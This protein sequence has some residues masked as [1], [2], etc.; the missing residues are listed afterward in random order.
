MGGRTVRVARDSVKVAIDLPALKLNVVANDPAVVLPEVRRIVEAFT[1]AGD[2]TLEDI[3][4]F[5]FRSRLSEEFFHHQGLLERLKSALVLDE[6]V[7]VAKQVI[8]LEREYDLATGNENIVLGVARL[9]EPATRLLAELDVRSVRECLVHI[10][11]ELSPE[12]QAVIMDC[13][14]QSLG[15]HGKVRFFLTKKNLEGH[16][17]LEAV[18]FLA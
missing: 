7:R 2:S 17:L 14:R 6:D 11:G 3:E 18:C 16:V 4:L 8:P 15:F 10:R 1:G 12:D 9:K 13:V 5:E